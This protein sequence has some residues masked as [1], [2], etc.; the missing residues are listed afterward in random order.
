MIYIYIYFG[1]LW[2]EKIV[3]GLFAVYFLLVIIDFFV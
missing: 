2:L 3:D 1:V